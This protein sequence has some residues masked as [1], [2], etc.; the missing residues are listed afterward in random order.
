MDDV[1]WILYKLNKKLNILVEAAGMGDKLAALAQ[2]LRGPT[3]RLKAAVEAN[4][5]KEKKQNG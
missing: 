2:E 1:V 3:E 5:P 4:Q